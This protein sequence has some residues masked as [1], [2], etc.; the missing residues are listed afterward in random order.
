MA[1][2]NPHSFENFITSGWR[3]YF[4]LWTAIWRYYV[5]GRVITLGIAVLCTL[6]LGFFGWFI[7]IIIWVPYWAWSLATLWQ[8][9]PNSNWP[10][11]AVPIRIW[12]YFEAVGAIFY[13]DRLTLTA[14]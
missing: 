3:G 10:F 13:I 11:L 9:A 6:Y 14:W 12:V 4:P 7:A 8:C 2:N 1:L 5:L